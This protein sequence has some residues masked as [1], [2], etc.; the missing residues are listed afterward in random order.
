MTVPEG[1]LC[2]NYCNYTGIK[3]QISASV[4]NVSAELLALVITNLPE[5]LALC[6]RSQVYSMS[7]MSR[8]F[9]SFSGCLVSIIFKSLDLV[10]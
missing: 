1:H 5:F 2:C 10:I 7:I 9:I 3:P 4:N 6:K 8:D